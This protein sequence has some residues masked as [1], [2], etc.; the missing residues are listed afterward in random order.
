MRQ[1]SQAFHTLFCL[2]SPAAESS[3]GGDGCECECV[4]VLARFDTRCVG[5]AALALDWLFRDV[6][7]GRAW[8]PS[9]GGVGMLDSIFRREAGKQTGVL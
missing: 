4:L 3:W 9:Y 2:T 6:G 5:L 8:C 7:F 1:R